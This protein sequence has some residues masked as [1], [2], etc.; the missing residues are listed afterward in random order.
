MLHLNEPLETQARLNRYVRALGVTYFVVVV[1]NFLHKVQSLQVLYYLLAAV[2]AVHAVV[3]AYVGLQFLLNGVHVQVCVRREDIDGLQVVF[4]SQRI[5]VHVMRRRH[6]QTTRTETYLH[7]AVLDNRYHAPYTRYNHLLALQ[8]LVLL[9]LRVDTNGDIAEDGL[10]T[11][12]S[13]NGVLTRLFRYLITQV[14]EFRMLLVVDHL[15]VAQRCLT[16]RIPVHHTQSAVDKT[17]LI[18]VAEDLDNGL[19]ARLVHRERGTVPVAGTTEFT[20]LLENDASVLVRPC[21]RMFQ[22]LF[23]GKV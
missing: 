4:L 6:L 13:H 7:I 20:E 1:L 15:L 9:F 22:E 23:A 3:L 19:A 2:E 17:F 5:V 21:P 11:G 14:V 10:R 8:P 12:G 18:Q 16:L